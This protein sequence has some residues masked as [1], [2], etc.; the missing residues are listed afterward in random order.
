[1]KLA[2]RYNDFEVYGPG[3]SNLEATGLY[4]CALDSRRGST[5]FRNIGNRYRASTL[6]AVDRQP[7]KPTECKLEVNLGCVS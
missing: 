3:I 5:N 4:I 2:Q 6:T 1:M 7:W